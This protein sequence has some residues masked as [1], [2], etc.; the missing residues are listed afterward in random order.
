MD[1]KRMRLP[2]FAARKRQG[3]KIVMLTAYDATMARLLDRAGV[4]AVDLAEDLRNRVELLDGDSAHFV[5]EAAADRAV[6]LRVAGL[7]LF[8][9][10]EEEQ[11][12]L[13]DRAAE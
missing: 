3:E 9:S 8:V 4:D 2:D 5:G 6:V 11:A 7:L 10:A 12:V 1:S 13:E